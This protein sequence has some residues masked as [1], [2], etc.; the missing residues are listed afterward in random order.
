MPALDS[1]SNPTPGDWGIY[2]CDANDVNGEWCWEMDIIEA[3]MYA[4]QTTPHTCDQAP[5]TPTYSC[6]RAG[7][8]TNTYYEN[9][10]GMCPSSACTINTKYPFDFS[11]TMNSDSYRVKMEQNGQTFEFDVCGDDS[12]LSNMVQALDFGMVLV[13]SYWGS[14]YSIMSW[15]DGPTGC[16]GNCD[17]PGNITFSDISISKENG[18]PVTVDPSK[19]TQVPNDGEFELKENSNVNSI[20]GHKFKT[21]EGKYGSKGRLSVPE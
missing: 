9:N 5:G 12:Y 8:G 18:E 7:C 1:N 6:D 10:S 11:I 2:Y 13:I 21:V 4:S 3:N 17:N 15:L 14:D 20:K 16:T 19:W